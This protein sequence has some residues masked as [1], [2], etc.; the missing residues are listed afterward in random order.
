MGIL[1][2][3]LL[4]AFFFW[5]LETLARYGKGLFNPNFE[6]IDRMFSELQQVNTNWNTLLGKVVYYG[7]LFFALLFSALF[8]ALLYYQLYGLHR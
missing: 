7:L 6:R 8:I 2:L 3:I 5:R 1:F 4:P